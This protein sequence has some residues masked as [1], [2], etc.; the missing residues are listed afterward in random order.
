M[1]KRKLVI[2]AGILVVFALMT[3]ACAGNDGT[4]SAPGQDGVLEPVTIQLFHDEALEERIQ[5]IQ[6]VIDSFTAQHPH[7][8]VQQL[9][10][11]DDAFSMCGDNIAR[12]AVF[13]YRIFQDYS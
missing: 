12:N 9:P 6:S 10:S 2:L 4:T 1:T 3:A 7:I 8:T 11:T 5:A 13:S